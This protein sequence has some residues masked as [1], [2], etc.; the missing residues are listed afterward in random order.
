MTFAGMLSRQVRELGEHD[1][2][3]LLERNSESFVCGNERALQ[4]RVTGRCWQEAA[5]R[6]STVAVVAQIHHYSSTVSTASNCLL[7]LLTTVFQVCL[8]SHTLQ[9]PSLHS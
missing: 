8:H 7:V 5:L 2:Q 4:N 1:E 9:R 3:V 6:W